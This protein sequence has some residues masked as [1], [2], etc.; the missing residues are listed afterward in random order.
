MTFSD[1]YIVLNK[2]D[3]TDLSWISVLLCAAVK[4]GEQIK[5]FI[6]VKM[7][8]F[9]QMCKCV[10]RVKKTDIVDSI[11]PLHY[12]S[13]FTG[14]APL[15][16]AYT[17]DKQGRVRVTLKTSVPAVLYTVLWYSLMT[18][19]EQLQLIFTTD[20][21]HRSQRIINISQHMIGIYDNKETLWM[22]VRT[23][24]TYIHSWLQK[25]TDVTALHGACDLGQEMLT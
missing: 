16:L 14:L 5:L 21:L 20:P 24:N 1:W 13:K 11:I 9:L 17:H 10:R 15:S 7:K 12:L 18:D 19:T 2:T 23:Q 3:S 25:S 4:T 22:S 6:T 8:K